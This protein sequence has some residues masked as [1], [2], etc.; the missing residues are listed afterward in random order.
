MCIRPLF[1]FGWALQATSYAGETRVRFKLKLAVAFHQNVLALLPPSLDISF[2]LQQP[3]TS[4]NRSCHYD[5]W[6][7]CKNDDLHHDCLEDFKVAYAPREQD[8]FMNPAFMP[9]ASPGVEP[10]A[11]TSTLSLDHV[12]LLAA[13]SLVLHSQTLRA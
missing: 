10:R 3:A 6:L 1:F 11:P 13:H 5:D 9:T 4:M 12:V 2:I 8:T 7:N